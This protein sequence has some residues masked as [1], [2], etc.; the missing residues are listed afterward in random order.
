[1]KANNNVWRHATIE[2]LRKT[3]ER[4][5]GTWDSGGPRG[6]ATV[7][8]K[9]RAKAGVYGKAQGGGHMHE[10]LGGGRWKG[11]SVWKSQ[12]RGG[13]PLIKPALKNWDPAEA[14]CGRRVVSRAARSRVCRASGK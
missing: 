9:N 12:Q 2:P 6:A 7:C 4:G 3:T 13:G 5:G 10:N 11:R 8:A 1:V 14:K